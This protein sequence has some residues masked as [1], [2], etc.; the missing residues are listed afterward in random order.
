VGKHSIDW[1]Y[2]KPWYH[3]TP[4]KIYTIFRGSTITQDRNLARIFSHKPTLVSISD[5]G[6]IKHNGSTPGFLYRIDDAIQ[7]NDVRPHPNSSM[8]WGMEWLTNREL[9][10]KLID[11]TAVVDSERLTEREVAELMKKASAS[12][13][14]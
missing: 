12:P 6:V 1:D 7:P 10:V 14:G 5:D 4:L 2:S 9:R 3:G 11:R 13:S 8:E